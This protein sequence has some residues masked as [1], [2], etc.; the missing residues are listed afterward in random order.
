MSIFRL[1]LNN[2]SYYRKPYLAILAGTLV[3]TAVL[4]GALVVGDSVKYSLTLIA[5]MRLGNTKY[6]LTTPDRFFRQQL[7][8]SLA[9]SMHT[10]ATALLQ[11]EGLAVNNDKNTRINQVSV[12]GI[13]SCFWGF[14]NLQAQ[15]I[16]DDEAIISRNTAEK[17]QL[18]PGDE[19]LLKVR[20]QT[21]APGN[22]PFVAEKE[23]LV[24]IRLKVKSIAAD[25]HMGRFSL[26]SNQ[27]APY[28]VFISSKLL[29]EK[30]DLVGM[31]NQ[32]LIA[33]P[34][35]DIQETAPD[36]ILQ[37]C[38][39][40]ED[41]GLLI[42]AT[43]QPGI[44]EIRS[45]RIFID[46]PTAR[47]IQQSVPY[48]HAVLT[49]LVNEIAAKGNSTPYSFVSALD[50]NKLDLAD[51]EIIINSWLA[52]DLHIGAGDKL[53]L[54]Y[55]KMGSLRKLTEDSSTFIVKN[56]L[57]VENV[58]FDRSLMPDF[59]GMSDAG[60]CREWETGAPVDLDKIRDKD[61]QYWNDFKGTPKAILSFKAGKKLWD[62]A[63]GN[64]TAYRFASDSSAVADLKKL[65][66]K[67]LLPAQNGLIFKD[68][69]AE[70]KQAA[71][72]S[73]DFGELFLSLSF[74]IIVA[75]L[76]L[77]A[78]LFSLHAGSR[79]TETAILSTLGFTK[80]NIA[81]LLA[82]ESFMVVVTGSIAGTFAGIGYTKL[83][84]LGLNTLWQDAVRT[85]MLQ[86]HLSSATLFSGF[87][88]GLLTAFVT[89][90]T[91][92][93]NNL[94]KP[95]A[96]MVKGNEPASKTHSRNAATL[97][98]VFAA[99]LFLTVVF[100]IAMPLT[101]HSAVSAAN[102]LIAGAALLI[103]GILALNA[104]LIKHKSTI[105]WQRKSVFGFVK[106]N[107]RYKRYRTIMAVS[108]LA[109]GTF[110][111]IVTGANRKTF[112]GSEK[113]VKSGSGGFAFWV[114]STVP[115]LN[116]LNTDEGKEKYGLTGETTLENVR[117]VQMPSVDGNDA[118]C[119]NLN[120]VLQP[121]ILGIDA[122]LFDSRQAFSFEQTD[123]SV[124]AQ[125]PWLT[126]DEAFAD[127]LI[128]AFADQT[129]IT[130]GIQKKVGDTLLYT[131]ESG[132]PLKIKLMG[133]LAGSVFQGHL[134][135]SAR[136][137]Q[138]HFPS[139]AGSKTMLI[140]GSFS[141][142]SAVSETLEYLF[143][144]FGMV[145]TPAS[146]RLAEFNSVTNTYLSVFMLL[147]ALGI[148]I[149]TIGLGIVLLRNVAERKT[150]LA[151]YQSLGFTKN[152]VFRIIF[153]ENLIILFAGIAIG[154]VSAFAGIIPSLVSPAFH[155]PAATILVLLGIISANG[156]FWIYFPLRKAL[157]RNPVGG[158]R[159]E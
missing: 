112:Y 96:A 12:L 129:V 67:N 38:W 150:E 49:Y 37:K 90:F 97:S 113:S 101:G 15:P 10:P 149:G 72:H 58:I 7:S 84:L 125:H 143:Q 62:N 66:A 153:T 137:L 128:P 48:S 155:L 8:A 61:E 85:N 110:T 80:R 123:K 127:D 136:H 41:A 88:A 158:L 53:Q 145:I 21:P 118:S 99:A 139:V 100:L 32:L 121:T 106:R 43:P 94:R 117:F 126:L 122:E 55:F 92:L 91:V 77:I 98:V 107:L 71:T 115:I 103:S 105:Q 144:D 27:T 133:G 104:S 47:A 141:N 50:N 31:A 93:L 134:L 131:S 45:K 3:S 1:I 23:P 135:I 44:F 6:A 57:P 159:N 116:D 124:S 151:L 20:K 35:E 64:A 34:N 102:F 140:D 89:L 138:K 2:I 83:L 19:F 108:L 42:K 87:I 59:P 40:T 22:A 13:D 81:Y 152:L 142:Q 11:L 86:L 52:N 56:V 114:E 154:S 60:N 146:Q 51:N 157:Q 130:W 16:P 18:Q 30:T 79:I 73:T 68:V 26:K 120:Q 29:A 17:L 36:S 65:L 9:D 147:S 4:T 5:E 39:Q 14:W 28:S 69:S 82:A 46:E 119:L 95:L 63:F 74:F 76:L 109:L 148:I 78:L 111:V 33:A 54:K 132:K 25:E 70:G 156:I 24:S 75:A